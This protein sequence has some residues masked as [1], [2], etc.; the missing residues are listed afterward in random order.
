MKRVQACNLK[1]GAVKWLEEIEKRTAGYILINGN[2]SEKL[3]VDVTLIYSLAIFTSFS[4]WKIVKSK[5]NYVGILFNTDFDKNCNS[6][7]FCQ[8]T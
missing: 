8:K 5:N 7:Q 3:N 1:S 6:S 4:N 2:I